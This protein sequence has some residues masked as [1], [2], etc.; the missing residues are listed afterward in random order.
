M[1]IIGKTAISRFTGKTG[2]ITYIKGN[3]VFVSFEYGG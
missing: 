1:S 2:T 3:K